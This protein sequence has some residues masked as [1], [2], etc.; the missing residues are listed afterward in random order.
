MA[1][2]KLL[3]DL[4]GEIHQYDEIL[5]ELKE[6]NSSLSAKIPS[7]NEVKRGSSRKQVWEVLLLIAVILVEAFVFWAWDATHR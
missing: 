2:M 7:L 1:V 6:F 3:A 4:I 5:R